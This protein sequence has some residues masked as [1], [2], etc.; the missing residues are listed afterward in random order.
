M[1]FTTVEII[2]V[3]NE[4]LNGTTLN[5]NSHWLAQQV[6]QLAAV[7]S[8]ITVIG[9]DLPAVSGVFREALRRHPDWILCC[10][11]LGPTFDDLTLEGLAKALRVPLRL[12]Q[13]ARNMLRRRY[14][15][16]VAQG[17]L[18]EVQ[19]TPARAKMAT[20]PRGSRPLRN[21]VGSAPGVLI[22]RRHTKLVCLPGVPHEMQAIFQG[23]VAP[24][25]QR[26]TKGIY[27]QEARVRVSA[28]VESALAPLVAKVMTRH[29]KV[30]IKSHPLG[31]EN[32][33]VQIQIQAIAATSS[34]EAAAS[35][36]QS[37]LR[38]LTALIEREGGA[39]A[40]QAG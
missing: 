25:I 19:W 29:P 26:D 30:Y 3:G 4:L 7:V 5:T 1:K 34:P 31:I 28:I 37:A 39:V 15:Q 11:G 10:G 8:R 6:T 18:R 32:G 14:Q 17:V 33:V 38:M 20:L 21:P 40:P 36:V 23:S 2:A 13:R 9:D 22:T 24:L 16:L 27:R 35:S 12:N